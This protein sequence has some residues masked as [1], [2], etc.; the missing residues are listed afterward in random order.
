MVE[1]EIV[2]QAESLHIND[3]PALDIQV[4]TGVILEGGV[5]VAVMPPRYN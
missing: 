3:P 1:E 2:A 4:V 5:T